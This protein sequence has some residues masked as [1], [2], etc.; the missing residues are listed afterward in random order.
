MLWPEVS[1]FLRWDPWSEIRR[2]MLLG[3]AIPFAEDFPPLNIWSSENDILI[4]AEMPGIEADKLDIAVMNDSV[5]ISGSRQEEQPGEGEAY[6]RQERS[7]GRF[8][9]SLKLPFRV[10]SSKVDARYEKGIL[11]I[12]L[13]RREQD[14]PKRIQIK[15]E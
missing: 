1:S 9:R 7:H 8:S 13:P 11:K 12:S 15:A 14:K 3:R 2:S 6:H 5:T 4:M 10:D